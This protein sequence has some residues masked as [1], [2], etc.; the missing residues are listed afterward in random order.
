MK[1]RFSSMVRGFTLIEILVVIAIIGILAA[2][3]MGFLNSARD[4]ANIAKAKTEMGQI[5]RAA[6][7]VYNDYGYYPNNSYSTPVC[8]QDIVIDQVTGKK[9]GDYIK[10]CTDPWGNFYKWENKCGALLRESD[11]SVSGCP[12]FSEQNAGPVGVKVLG[13]DDTDNGCTGDDICT[14][15][16]GYPVYGF[17]GQTTESQGEQLMCVNTVS[18]CANLSPL[19]CISRSGCT[20]TAAGCTGNYSGSCGGLIQ[21]SCSSSPGCSWSAGSCSGTPPSCS[22]L[23]TSGAC[24]AANGCSWSAVPANCSGTV[25]CSAYNGASSTCTS[26]G[27]SYFSTNCTGGTYLCSTWSGNSNSTF[28]TSHTGCTW[29]S[30]GPAYTCSGSKACTA[31][32]TQATCAATPTACTWHPNKCEGAPSCVSTWTGTTCSG[33]SGCTLNT[34]TNTCT[35]T[36]TCNYGDS[37]SCGAGG[38][39]WTTPSC[40]GTF[41]SSC[42]SFADQSSCQAQS[43]CSWSAGSC[44]GTAVSC[45]TFSDQNSCSSQSGC[46]WQ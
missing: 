15:S 39:N 43:S 19:G 25:T 17:D 38:C 8:P 3:V 9:W 33:T 10:I 36:S 34:A 4:K 24:G 35:G 6:E 20:L 41:S 29:S 12:A 28:C 2:V 7:L 5:M 22:S 40:Q 26:K 11:N 1:S 14:G 31:L 30:T 16:R 46:S 32:T 21:T 45:T 27:C 42:G 13:S 18:S 23:G 44:T 37:A